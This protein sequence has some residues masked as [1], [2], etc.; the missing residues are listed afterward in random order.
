MKDTTNY[1]LA[2]DLVHREYT[3]WHFALIPAGVAILASFFGF[4]A[5]GGSTPEER[6]HT[7]QYQLVTTLGSIGMT[8]AALVLVVDT[9]HE[10]SALRHAVGTGALRTVEGAISELTPEGPGGHPSERFRVDSVIYTYSTYNIT[11]GFR[12]TI[13]EGGPIRAGQRVRISDVDGTIVRLEI[14]R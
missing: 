6:R 9:W 7:R 10:Y 3:T 1:Q 12:Q 4:L 2:F 5:R 13:R 8:V 14:A 11:P